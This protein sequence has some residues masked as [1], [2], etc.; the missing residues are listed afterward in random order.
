MVKH[1]D[2]TA[3]MNIR[4]EADAIAGRLAES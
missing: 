1:D 2:M 3:A 4:C